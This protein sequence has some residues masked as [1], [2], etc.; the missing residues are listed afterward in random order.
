MFSHS[1]PL[2]GE[3]P[4]YLVTRKNAS[5]QLLCLGGN[6]VK[7]NER[8]DLRA[9]ADMGTDLSTQLRVPRQ[10]LGLVSIFHND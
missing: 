3:F 5:L 2:H 10:V 9:R 6:G 4:L 8:W 7:R 1:V